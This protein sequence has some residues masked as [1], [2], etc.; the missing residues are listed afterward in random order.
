MPL[1]ICLQEK[2]H[3]AGE[4]YQRRE[5][6]A[7]AAFFCGWWEYKLDLIRVR[8]LVLH[9]DI[10]PRYIAKAPQSTRTRLSRT[11]LRPAY[12]AQRRAV[13]TGTAACFRSSIPPVVKF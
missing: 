6:S 9:L 8:H 3:V 12:A 4:I 2:A 5:V 10:T 1:W 13:R 7:R 11:R